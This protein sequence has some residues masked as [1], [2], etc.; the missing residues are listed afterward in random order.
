M[1]LRIVVG[2]IAGLA[3]ST[4]A[5]ATT[6]FTEGFDGLA[7]NSLNVTALGPNVTVSGGVDVVGQVNNYGINNITTGNVID[8]DG[9]PGP[10]SLIATNAPFAF[11]AGDRITLSFL[12]SGSQRS[13]AA[14]NFFIGYT[15]GSATALKDITGTGY[16]NFVNFASAVAPSSG[17][18]SISLLGTAGFVQTSVS[19]TALQ[20]GTFGFSL[21][22]TSAD[23]VGPLIDNISLDISSAV[24]EPSTW[25]MMILGFAGVGFMAYRRRNQFMQTA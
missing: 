17:S 16:F 22:T 9:T 15:F 8:L 20:S 21:G 25:A 23:N 11:N 1:K 4:S 14:D 19:F 2:L 3:I 24:P 5:S 18:Q 10:G 13:S 6:V 7:S 12:L